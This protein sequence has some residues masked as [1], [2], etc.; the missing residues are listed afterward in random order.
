M[1]C[2][3]SMLCAPCFP[4]CDMNS[5]VVI[6]RYPVIWAQVWML[7]HIQ[8][9]SNI[10]DIYHPNHKTCTVI[11][12]LYPGVYME[13]WALFQTGVIRGFPVFTRSVMPW[14]Y[15]TSSVYYCEVEEAVNS[16][17]VFDYSLPRVAESV[18]V[19]KRPFT[20]CWKSKTLPSSTA[21]SRF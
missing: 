18:D 1:H 19:V 20:L 17:R 6:L 11:H 5:Y 14:L 10:K 4:R 9:P 13:G 7:T 3:F 2:K 15:E 16:Q 12:M 21:F 8:K